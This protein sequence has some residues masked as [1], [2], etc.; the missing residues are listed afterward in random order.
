MVVVLMIYDLVFGTNYYHLDHNLYKKRKRKREKKID[1]KQWRKTHTRKLMEQT[2]KKINSLSTCMQFF[3][4]PTTTKKKT[5]KTA[6]YGEG[7]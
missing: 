2:K 1:V 6:K 5:R 3:T 4:K 7:L